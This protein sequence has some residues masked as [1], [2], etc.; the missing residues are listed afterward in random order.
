MDIFYT[1]AWIKTVCFAKEETVIWI[2]LD[3][4]DS[5]MKYSKLARLNIHV[6]AKN[7]GA[8]KLQFF[9]FCKDQ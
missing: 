8:R 5:N 7:T 4:I 1:Q 2:L 9:S 3:E 6:N